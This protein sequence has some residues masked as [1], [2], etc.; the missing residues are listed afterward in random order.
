M[1]KRS[2]QDRASLLA[3]VAEMYYLEQ[4]NQA[5]IAKAVGVTRSMISRMLTEARESGIVEIRIQRPLQSDL[6]LEA[7]LTEQFGLKDVFVVI[8]SHRSGERLTRT[9]GSAGALMLKRYLA[10]ERIL[11]L[12]WGTSISATV[13]AFEVSEPMPV[14]VVQLVGA[15][16]ARIMEYD[17]H[18][19]VSRIT[20]KL[21]GDAYYLNAPYLCQSAEIA[22]SLLETKSIRETI[23]VGKKADVAL[24]GIGST[25]LE[26]SS[27]HLAGYVTRREL[28][29]LRRAGGI[30]DVCGLHFN[31]DGQPA[32]DDFCERLVSIRR[33]DL[34]SIPVR[35]GVAGGEGKADAILGALRSKYVNVLVIDS[36]TARKVLELAKSK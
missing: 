3:D 31:L 14:K 30:G 23:N 18:D 15:M 21:G 25:A 8:T 28:E 34:L 10:P 17:G 36:M 6:E 26:Y 16:G 24:L 22:Q 33:S 12:A 20:E 19:L 4:K 1:E 7:A 32:C 27:F 2:L 5:E 29:E 13:D 11:G 9:L 35:L